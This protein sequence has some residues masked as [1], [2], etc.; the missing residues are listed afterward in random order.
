MQAPR[1]I[2]VW[3]DWRIRIWP[4]LCGHVCPHPSQARRQ[5]EARTCTGGTVACRLIQ[6]RW[7]LASFGA[8]SATCRTDAKRMLCSEQHVNKTRKHN[9]NNAPEWSNFDRALVTPDIRKVTQTGVS[10]AAVGRHTLIHDLVLDVQVEHLL[11]D[12]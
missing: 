10:L 2:F 6:L 5:R 9:L 1:T 11:Q 12:L 3:V 7:W 4:R 8:F